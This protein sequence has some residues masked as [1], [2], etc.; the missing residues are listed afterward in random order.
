MEGLLIA[1]LLAQLKPL[2]PSDRLAWRFADPYTFI[3]PLKGVTLT[4]HNRPPTPRLELNPGTPAATGTQTGFQDLLVARASGRLL[5]VEQLQ[6]DRVVKLSFDRAEGFVPT[7]P[8]TLVAELTGRNCN[9]ILLDDQ[10]RILGAARDI[11]ADVNR[12]RQIRSGIPYTPPPP[13]SKL[14]PRSATDDQLKR[15]LIERPLKKLNTILDG[16]GPELTATVIQLSGLKA[17]EPLDQDALA[18]VLPVLRRV[19]QAP[20]QALQEALKL[21]D[22]A[23]LKRQAERAEKEAQLRDKLEKA[24]ALTERQLG[25]I[26]KARQAAQDAA[27]LREQADILMAYQYQVPKGAEQVMLTDFAGQARTI[28]LEPQLSALENAQLLYERAK[29][30][31]QRKLQAE[32]REPQLRERLTRITQQLETLSELS[33]DDLA[34][35]YQQL[36]PTTTQAKATTPGIRFSGP[37]QFDVLVGRSAKDNDAL[38]FKVAKSRDVWLHVQGYSGSHVIIQANNQEVPFD[39]ILFAAQLA[40]GYSKAAESENVPVDYTLRKHVWRPKGAAPGAVHYTQQKTVYVTPN[41][42]PKSI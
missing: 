22:I 33:E 26:D 27:R 41:R 2:L 24:R 21:P 7:P 38:T 28:R 40:A 23:T 9:L 1:E 13:Y 36:L 3:L 15:A 6:L 29:K 25:D 8:V 30:R 11:P 5:T 34:A 42:H 19:T 20:A 39:T 18:T 35:L 12:Y 14:D 10:E 31:E 16:F 32:A 4:I 17:N 37:H